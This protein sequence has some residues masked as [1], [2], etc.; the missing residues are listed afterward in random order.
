MTRDILSNLRPARDSRKKVKRIGR[1]QGSGHGGTA[2]K[3]HKGAKARS[4]HKFKIWFE[5]GQI[6]LTRRVPKHGFRSRNRDESRIVNVGQIEDLITRKKIDGAT[7]TPEVLYKAGA[8]KR[9]DEKVKIL[10][11]GTLTSKIQISAHAVSKAAQTKI[12][13]VGGTVTLLA[14]ATPAATA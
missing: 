14:P 7:I 8:I 9:K 2:T 3:G 6:P 5:G 11:D 13:A 1:G 10:A 12:E 4:G